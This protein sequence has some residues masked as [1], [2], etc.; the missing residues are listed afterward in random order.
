MKPV[1]R[2]AM[3]PVVRYAMKAAVRYAMKPVVRYAM[4][5]AV[6]SA[7]ESAVRFGCASPAAAA[8]LPF[9]CPGLAAW[10][11]GRTPEGVKQAINAH[12]VAHNIKL[13]HK[14]Q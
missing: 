1:V 4:K 11:P 8:V 14:L 10:L 2:Y 7:V 6:K 5:T 3:K 9:L 12:V 13:N